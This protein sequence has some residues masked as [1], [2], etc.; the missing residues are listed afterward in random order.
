M[1]QVNAHPWSRAHY[2]STFSKWHSELQYPI[3]AAVSLID[4]N[5]CQPFSRAPV[6]GGTCWGSTGLSLVLLYPIVSDTEEVKQT[7]MLHDGTLE[8]A[9]IC[10]SWNGL[11]SK[12]WKAG[13]SIRKMIHFMIMTSLSAL[14]ERRCRIKKSFHDAVQITIACAQATEVILVSLAIHL[15]GFCWV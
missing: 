13:F 10:I 14:F 7:W 6:R 9:N 11:T 12:I 2:P 4:R 1:T 8:E 5:S 15:N 3:A